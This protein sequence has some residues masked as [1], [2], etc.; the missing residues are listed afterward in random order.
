MFQNGRVNVVFNS[1]Q[2][3]RGGNSGGGNY[4]GQSS[5]D[6]MPSCKNEV[7]N[8]QPNVPR[9]Y[10]EVDQARVNG[11]SLLANFRVQPPNGPRSSGSCDVFKNGKMNVQ[12]NNC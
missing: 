6:A 10:I 2:G 8:R 11:G 7:S 1:N 5:L 4:G 12:Y 3:Y 9:A